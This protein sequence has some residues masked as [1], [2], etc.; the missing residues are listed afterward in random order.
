MYVTRIRTILVV[1]PFV[2]FAA[3]VSGYYIAKHRFSIRTPPPIVVQSTD[4]ISA[5][6]AWLDKNLPDGSTDRTETSPYPYGQELVQD[7]VTTSLTSYRIAAT[8][9]DTWRISSRERTQLDLVSSGGQYIHERTTDCAVRF[10]ETPWADSSYFDAYKGADMTVE[11]GKVRNSDY[12]PSAR[13]FILSIP[14][15]KLSCDIQ[16]HETGK[17]DGAQHLPVLEL[18]FDSPEGAESTLLTIIRYANPDVAK[19]TDIE[20]QWIRD[21]LKMDITMGQADPNDG[22]GSADHWMVKSSRTDHIISHGITQDLHSLGS[23]QVWPL[24]VNWSM[25]SVD[26]RPDGNYV[27]W[28]DDK[29]GISCD[30]TL[31]GKKPPM[32]TENGRFLF[33]LFP[34]ETSGH[35]W[36]AAVRQ[37]VMDKK[38]AQSSHL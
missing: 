38:V 30:W 2:V 29:N 31:L 37:H 36:L 5:E 34:T 10:R 12:D 33:L 16:Y 18:T 4:P 11:N 25:S 35:E 19:A 27:L 15:D 9:A 26:K 8:D 14:R 22:A 28:V 20:A 24:K 3:L 21:H 17:P 7:G 1:V 13:V 23:C 32:H 6:Q